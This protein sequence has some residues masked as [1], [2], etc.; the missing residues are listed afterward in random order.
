MTSVPEYLAEM[1]TDL[2]ASLRKQANEDRDGHLVVTVV[3]AG[4]MAAQYFER[5]LS[6]LLDAD[7][8]EAWYIS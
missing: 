5:Y 6:R 1:K 8:I 4:N 3:D 7:D 2:K